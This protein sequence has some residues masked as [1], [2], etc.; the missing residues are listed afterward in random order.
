MVSH[1]AVEVIQFATNLLDAHSDIWKLAQDNQLGTQ[2]RG[3][4][5]QG[6]LS[7]KYFN[8]SPAFRS[9]DNRSEWCKDED[10]TRFAILAE[11]LPEGMTMGQAAIRWILDHPGAHTICMGAKNIEDYRTAIAASEMPALGT[12]TRATLELTAETVI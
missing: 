7:G 4:M 11:C 2:L 12:A 9:D 5:A 6:R 1:K 3:V 8:Q 10:Y